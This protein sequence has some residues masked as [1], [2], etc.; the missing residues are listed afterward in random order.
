MYEQLLMAY[1][2]VNIV[3]KYFVQN[4][5][6]MN[7]YFNF[8]KSC[9]FFLLNLSFEK[10]YHSVIKSYLINLFYVYTIY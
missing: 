2:V 5:Q 7:G 4:N 6:N 10:Y 9:F 3:E 8:S 1:P